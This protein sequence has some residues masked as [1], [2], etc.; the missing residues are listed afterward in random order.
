MVNPSTQFISRRHG[1]QCSFPMNGSTCG[2]RR[3]HLL[4]FARATH[5]ES[6]KT[7]QAPVARTSSHCFRIFDVNLRAPFYS[8]EVTAFFV[9]GTRDGF[10][11]AEEIE[12]ALEL[13]LV[14]NRTLWCRGL[15][16]T[17]RGQVSPFDA[18]WALQKP[19]PATSPRS[20]RGLLLSSVGF[21]HEPERLADFRILILVGECFGDLPLV[22]KVVVSQW[23]KSLVREGGFTAK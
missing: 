20:Q 4:R 12:A 10:G 7:I 14:P 13:V 9:H 1:I 11:S 5:L 22:E 3:R 19:R 18:M 6:R 17:D 16:L 21:L 23:A 2:A 15:C 8:A